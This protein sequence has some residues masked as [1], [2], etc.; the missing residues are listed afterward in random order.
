[1]ISPST[2]GARVRIADCT[3][4]AHCT[5]TVALCVGVGLTLK[6]FVGSAGAIFADWALC[7]PM[8]PFLLHVLPFL[9]QVLPALV[10]WYISASHL[11][12]CPPLRLRRPPQPTPPNITPSASNNSTTPAAATA[13]A[14]PPANKGGWQLLPPASAL[15]L[16]TEA[17]TLLRNY[18]WPVVIVYLTKDFFSFL[19]HRLSQRLTNLGGCAVAQCAG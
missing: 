6:Y 2:T 11:S 14:P 10:R 12:P 3:Q 13:A 16:L 9:L 8:L 19:L 17:A 15:S 5:Q 7:C 1:M 4:T 18:F